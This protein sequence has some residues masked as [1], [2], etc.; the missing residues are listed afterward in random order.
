MFMLRYF[1][2]LQFREEK[3]MKFAISAILAAAIAALSIDAAFAEKNPPGV[4]PEHYACYRVTPSQP[5]KPRQVGLVDQFGKG[6]AVVVRAMYLCAP[7]SKNEE[8]IKDERTHLLCYVLKTSK[9]ANK[10]A[11]VVNQFGESLMKIG[12]LEQLCVPSLKQIK[13]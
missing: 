6:V 13:K 1:D 7:V 4:N 9:A 5:F 2:V 11:V 3:L 12:P 8:P 10:V